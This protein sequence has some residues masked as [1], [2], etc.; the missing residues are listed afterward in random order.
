[1]FCVFPT[2]KQLGVYHYFQDGEFTVD[3]TDD[4]T[5]IKG[6]M[7]GIDEKYYRLNLR[8]NGVYRHYGFPVRLITETM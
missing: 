3:T 4:T 2:E 5:T 8:S 7:I 1:M 6:W